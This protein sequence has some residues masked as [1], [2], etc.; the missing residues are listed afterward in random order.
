MAGRIPQSFI[1]E[2]LGR[3]DLL[4]VIDSKISLKKSG[5]NYL[6]CCPFHNE[7]TPSFSVNPHKQFYHCFGCGVS[8]NAITFI[9]EYE[10]LDFVS[11]IEELASQAGLQV[12][13]EMQSNFA[14]DHVDLFDVMQK[15]SNFYQQQLKT[16]PAAKAAVNYL[17]DRGLSGEIAK[18]Y[19]IGYAPEQWQS[20]LHLSHDQQQLKKQLVDSGM[21]IEK[22]QGHCYDRFRDRIMFPI[23][24]RRGQVVGFGGR[25]IDKGEPKYLNSPETKLFHKSQQLYGLYE[26][27]RQLNKIDSILVVEGYMDVVALAQ[28]GIA[29]AVATLGTATTSEH[30]QA[31]FRITSKIVLCFDGDNAGRSAA[32]RAVEHALP[33]LKEARE[34]RLMFL[35]D[36]ED[37]D[38][39]IRKIGAQEFNQQIADSTTLFDYL[40]KHLTDQV[41]MTTFEGPAK[42]LHFSKPFLEAITDTFLYAKFEQ[43]LSELTGIGLKRL[44][45]IID[46]KQDK[47][48]QPANKSQPM[49]TKAKTTNS[50]LY[51][52]AI[53]LL[54]QYP[55][56]LS[57][58]DVS[59]L[60]D[61]V[62]PG[63]A[64]LY[65]L[66][67]QTRQ[68][69]NCT[70][71]I[72]LEYWRETS[73]Y[74][75][76]L[77]LA[78]SELHSDEANAAIELQEMFLRIKKQQLTEQWDRLVEKSSI[79]PLNQ[80]DKQTLKQ[81][82][83]TIAKL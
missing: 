69:S 67:Q 65:K 24:N 66:C 44:Q 28:F 71:A 64:I 13:K 17:K 7:K 51:R 1:Q 31:L 34:V 32:M 11:T 76:L 2:L 79:Q 18:Q 26:M 8:G 3:I 57:E 14:A 42:L 53:A 39:L 55:V 12:P 5:Q 35:A 30:M 27:R 33:L 81:L 68:S 6:A 54:I 82:Q 83:E 78:G 23:R 20:L 4:E 29:N 52:R 19:A 43:S 45:Q 77:K 49:T 9:M 37:P 60:A 41:D 80:E 38:S 75:H 36:G 10:G 48:S 56:A 46:K 40:I 63:G 22:E 16:N 21:M 15:V 72:L 47:A 25:I 58:T 70:T 74:P 62:N 59:W 61:N 50:S 73:E